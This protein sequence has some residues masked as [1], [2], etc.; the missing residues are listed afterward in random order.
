MCRYEEVFTASEDSASEDSDEDIITDY[1]SPLDDNGNLDGSNDRLNI[2]NGNDVQK[3][4]TCG[5]TDAVTGDAA[6][7]SGVI[8]TIS[9]TQHSP[10]AGKTFYILGKNFLL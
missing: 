6:D 3:M 10:A 5:A 4:A 2:G 9:I 7:A 1:L 8:P